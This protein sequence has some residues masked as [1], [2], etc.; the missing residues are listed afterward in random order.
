ML[1]SIAY[2][3]GSLGDV[4]ESWGWNSWVNAALDVLAEGLGVLLDGGRE[5]HCD[6]G[7][8]II[9]RSELSG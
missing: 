1:E 4:G 6:C 2:V 8:L 7:G 9:W 5:R 3:G